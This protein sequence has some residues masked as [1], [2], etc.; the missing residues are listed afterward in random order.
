VF[1]LGKIILVYFFDMIFFDKDMK[2]Y[3]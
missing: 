1:V 2:I 3:G